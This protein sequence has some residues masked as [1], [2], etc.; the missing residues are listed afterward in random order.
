M[1]RAALVVSLLT[2]ARLGAPATR[3]GPPP[4]IHASAPRPPLAPE[5]SAR[6]RRRAVEYRVAIPDPASQYVEVTMTVERARSRRTA[7]AMPAWIPGSYKIRDYA[8]H[9][10]G[11]R[12]ES[13]DGRPLEI[14]KRD[15]QTWELENQRRGF[16]VRYRVFAD[17]RSVRTNLVDTQH[18]VLNSPALLLY[19]VGEL[20]RAVSLEV[21]PPPG[22]QVHAPLPSARRARA[23]APAGTRRFAAES[24]DE[25][26][27]SPLLLG[28][29]ALRH[30]S[31]A[32]A[33]VELVVSDVA[34]G[35]LDVARAAA[36][37][38]TI[39]QTYARLMGGLPLARY[40]MFLEAGPSDGGGIE[41]E[42]SALMMVARDG[43]GR[44]DGYRKLAHLIAHEFFHL[45]NVKRIHDRALGP[46]DYTREVHS[47]LLWFH[48]GFTE[49]VENQALVRA[50]LTAAQEY[51]DALAGSWTAYQRK[52]GRDHEPISLV[53][54]DAWTRL[55]QSSAR[56]GNSLVSYYEKGHLIGVALDL[57]LRLRSATRGRRGALV[58]VFR[59]LMASHGARDV[60]IEL[61]DIIDAASAEAG[62]DMTWFFR[63]HV[64]G[65]TPLQLPRL[66]E[67]IGV[68]VIS[69]A[70]WQP[71][72]TPPGAPPSAG[73]T[74]AELQRLRAW[75]GL[76]LED[77][78]VDNVEPGSPAAR[79]GLMLGDELIAIDRRRVR[80]ADD[81]RE[82]LADHQPGERVVLSLFRS[83]QL[84]EV[85][86]LVALNPHREFRLEL[87]APE[88]L[89]PAI[90]QL[91]DDWLATCDPASPV[92]HCV[93]RAPAS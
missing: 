68:R 62:E 45:W 85:S 92:D 84:H 22:W 63:R 54:H 73:P 79:A 57:E 6:A 28:T 39:V 83:G 24:Y 52:P 77:A 21:A 88:A 61:Q 13:L 86:V 7:V 36:D 17:E 81:I 25:L 9:V 53:S 46:F 64:E 5:R 91:R 72:P 67:A 55:Y 34:R 87:V 18:A 90:R 66:L 71:P 56:D 2:T 89:A 27:D 43:F 4:T 48:E 37:A 16:R 11:L 74:P 30:F 20:D 49:T 35:N 76:S 75:I 42:R 14:R 70:P 41:H 23:G 3:D 51:L 47:R 1:L 32:G 29:P 8:R 82:R 78:R 44:E 12:A 33:R 19:V 58:G 59:R 93:L 38:R 26:V 69:R 80:S 50:G 40:V 31:V 15:K 65:T 60:G 10:D